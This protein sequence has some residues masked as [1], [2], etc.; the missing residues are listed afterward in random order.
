[1]KKI[2]NLK[3]AKKFRKFLITYFENGG[4]F[5]TPVIQALSP[6]VSTITAIGQNAVSGINEMKAKHKAS[7]NLEGFS[8]V[9]LDFNPF[10]E[11]GGELTKFKGPSHSEGGIPIDKNMTPNNSNPI[12]EVEG[13]ETGVNLGDKKYIFSDNLKLDDLTFA[14]ESK[15]ID[16]KYKRKDDITK[17]TKEFEL[18]RLS[19]E[20]DIVKDSNEFVKK[21]GGQIQE[22]MKGGNLKEYNNGGPIALPTLQAPLVTGSNYDDKLFDPM[23]DDFNIPI[24]TTDNTIANKREPFNFNKLA[25]GLKGAA[26]GKSFIDSLQPSEEENLQLNPEANKVKD[27]VSNL[28]VDLSSAIDDILLG[29]NSALKNAR[30]VSGS[31]ITSQV[32]GQ[33]AIDKGNRAIADLEIQEQNAN[34]ALRSQEA[35][36]RA[37]LGSEERQERVRQQTV[38]D[39]N[40]AVARGFGRD[41]F[42]NL[43]RIGSEFNKYQYTQDQIA[44][45]KEIAEMTIA[46][47]TAL[48]SQR[49]PDFTITENLVD[50]IKQGLA[51]GSITDI[52]QYIRY[53][54]KKKD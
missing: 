54:A 53:R 43:S 12:A 37:N 6:A 5:K 3:D 17:R 13:G 1:M 28:N 16:K 36:V 18:K 38:Q 15:K 45:Q 49:Y 22:Y 11:D 26:L 21:Y 44:N 50:A 2:N 46:E 14:E 20:N 42:S 23:F 27:I 10:M 4:E 9:N 52:N 35:Q 19:E 47:G 40:D 7:R 33:S 39:Q 30:N 24:E 41:L 29:T 32:L 31:A 25:L 34:N 51:D 48:L 8:G